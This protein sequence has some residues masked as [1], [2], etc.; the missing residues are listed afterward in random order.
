MSWRLAGLD[1]LPFAHWVGQA[2]DWMLRLM[3]SAARSD[4]MQRRD[5]LLVAVALGVGQAQVQRLAAR[6][7]SPAWFSSCRRLGRVVGVVRQ[8]AEVPEQ[9]GRDDAAGRDGRRRAAPR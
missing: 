7:R 1:D 4:L 6:A 2:S 9:A 8:V 5:D 3:F